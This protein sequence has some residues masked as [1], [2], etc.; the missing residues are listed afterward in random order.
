[1]G[2]TGEGVCHGFSGSW[3]ADVVLVDPDRVQARGEIKRSNV[4]W[5]VTGS[6]TDL[7]RRRFSAVNVFSYVGFSR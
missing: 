2:G 6:D 5:T 7:E 1:M 3:N 4:K